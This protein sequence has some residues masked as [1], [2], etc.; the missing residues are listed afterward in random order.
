MQTSGLTK[1]FVFSYIVGKGLGGRKQSLP[2]DCEQGNTV[3]QPKIKK[4]TLISAF[5]AL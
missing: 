1:A 2:H 5:L 4:I 3:Y